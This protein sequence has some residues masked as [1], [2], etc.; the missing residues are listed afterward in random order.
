[1]GETLSRI[2][3]RVQVEGDPLPVFYRLPAHVCSP[4]VSA[5]ADGCPR[6]PRPRVIA[7]IR[8]EVASSALGPTG[9][10]SLAVL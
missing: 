9:D 4:S 1:M 3:S 5:D 2:G 10:L 7:L 8:E 6:A